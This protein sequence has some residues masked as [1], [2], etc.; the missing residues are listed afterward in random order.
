MRIRSDPG[1][2]GVVQFC[3]LAATAEA[4]SGLGPFSEDSHVAIALELDDDASA[5]G[6]FPRLVAQELVQ[7]V[8]PAAAAI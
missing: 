3:N 1:K 5:A 2:L 8:G 4:S 6:H 7:L